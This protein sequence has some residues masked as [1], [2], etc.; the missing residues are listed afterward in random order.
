MIRAVY[1]LMKSI[2]IVKG[3]RSSLFKHNN[4][5]EYHI[6]VMRWYWL[7]KKLGQ[8]DKKRIGLNSPL[9]ISIHGLLIN[10]CCTRVQKDNKRCNA[11]D[12]SSI[13]LIVDQPL[14]A[15]IINGCKWVIY[16]EAKD[17]EEKWPGPFS[18]LDFIA[19]FSR[20]TC[21]VVCDDVNQGLQC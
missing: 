3:I 1:Q 4:L 18:V 7:Y 21:T 13:T 17:R 15:Y 16:I 10:S 12:T 5:R 14:K 8:K 9:S 20:V 11:W 6:L 19:L 2:K